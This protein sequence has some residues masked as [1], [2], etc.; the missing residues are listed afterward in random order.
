[1]LFQR[2]Y[3]ELYVYISSL[4]S[5]ISYFELFTILKKLLFLNHRLKIV[6]DLVKILTYKTQS[7]TNYS[8]V[9]TFLSSIKLSVNYFKF[10]NK[11][12][13]RRITI[14]ISKIR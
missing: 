9:N 11:D 14:C 5:D 2:N 12:L 4:A 7:F 6:D 1:M 3:N 8:F 13:K 10:R